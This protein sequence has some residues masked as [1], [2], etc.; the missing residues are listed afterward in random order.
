MARNIWHTTKR[1]EFR[2]TKEPGVISWTPVALA[3]LAVETEMSWGLAK[4]KTTQ[5]PGSGRDLPSEEQGRAWQC[6]ILNALLW[7]L[8]T[9]T[10]AWNLHTWVTPH[11]CTHKINK[12]M[13]F[14]QHELS[15]VAKNRN[16]KQLIVAGNLGNR[17]LLFNKQRISFCTMKKFWRVGEQ[18]CDYTQNVLNTTE[19]LTTMSKW[20]KWLQSGSLL[21]KSV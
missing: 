7:P 11:V 15:W 13:K 10:G 21:L 3:M 4:A 1:H 12:Q 9:Y 20:L 5:T 2:L 19:L 14:H 16:R 17:D 6:R 8:R 18:E